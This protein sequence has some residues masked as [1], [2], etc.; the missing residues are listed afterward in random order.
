MSVMSV[1]APGLPRPADLSVASTPMSPTPSLSQELG[2]VMVV[3]DQKSSRFLLAELL[4]DMGYR[5][6]EIEGGYE[7]LESIGHE[8]PNSIVPDLI[9]LDVMMPGMDG[10]E[11]C[12]R[13]KSN[14]LT[15][16]IPVVMVTAASDHAN[17]VKGIEAGA[18]DFLGRPLDETELLARVRSLVH[19][20]RLNEDLDH[21]TQVLFAIA[22]TIESRDPTTGDHCERLSEMGQAFGKFLNLP[23]PLLKALDWAGYLHDIG[24]V[25][26]PDA[27]L[28]KKGKH[29]P[30]E[31]EVMKSHVLL[32]VDICQPM[33]TLRD[34]V[35]VIRHHH[36]RWDGGGYPDGLAGE[37]IP[38][39]AR[40]FQLLDIYDALRSKRPYKRAF[41]SHEA[42]DIMRSEVEQGWRDPNLFEQ[43][44]WFIIQQLDPSELN[45][46][47]TQ[48]EIVQPEQDTLT[49]VG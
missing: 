20:R 27:V 5:V 17:R 7:A 8:Q 35:P 42:L 22:R 3:D 28:N 19:Q 16:L 37:D 9:L 23:R 26:I 12:R 1:S 10:F 48:V 45:S 47:P 18:D 32:G 43:F 38:Y 49:P 4:R 24:K 11:V 36:E 33:Q 15:R 29:T 14:D 41:S 25:G 21:T 44:S 30:E 39:L 31:W 46:S 6:T 34:V 2:H 40:V 13:L